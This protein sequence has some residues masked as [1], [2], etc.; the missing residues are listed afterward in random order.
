MLSDS[1][2]SGQALPQSRRPSPRPDASLSLL[3]NHNSGIEFLS[4]KQSI[5]VEA[6]QR[7]GI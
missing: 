1:E 7:N 5:I 4:E 6:Y 2:A 3:M